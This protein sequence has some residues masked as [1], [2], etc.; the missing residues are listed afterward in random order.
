VDDASGWQ[1]VT[2][3]GFDSARSGEDRC[4]IYVWRS[5]R[6]G[7][8]TKTEKSR[9]TLALP[10]RCVAALRQHR[11]YLHLANDWLTSTCVRPS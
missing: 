1:P 3:A 5:Q 4:A 10:Q 7:G 6:K 2:T 11:V 9:R 8:D